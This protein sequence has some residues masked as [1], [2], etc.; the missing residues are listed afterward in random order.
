MNR[1]KSIVDCCFIYDEIETL[2]FRISELYDFVDYFIITEYD[3]DFEGKSKDF[4]YEK[5]NIFFLDWMDKIIY[6]KIES[7]NHDFKHDKKNQIKIFQ[8]EIFEKLSKMDLKFEDFI[9]FSEVDEI[10]PKFDYQELDKFLTYEPVAFLQKNFIGSVKYSTKE[11]H[12]GS[13]CFLLSHFVEDQTLIETLYFNKNSIN[14]FYYRI[15]EG[16]F[17][18]SHFADDESIIR[19]VRLNENKL[20]SQTEIS[21]F[22]KNLKYWDENL[23]SF[24]DYEGSLPKNISMIESNFFEEI[25]HRKF[26]VIL[27]FNQNYIEPHQFSDYDKIINLNFTSSFNFLPKTEISE[28][29]INYNIYIPNQ[30]YYESEKFELEF[31]FNEIKQI[32]KNYDPL[33]NDLFN[34]C[35]CDEKLRFEKTKTFSWREIKNNYMYQLLKNPS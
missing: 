35:I 25:T 5:K 3:L 9:I 17:H 20:I 32:L 22:K 28:N 15:L 34:F 31:G 18:F 12:L 11:K 23:N 1:K 2:K 19:K 33:N 21:L 26:M 14:S 30:K 6:L 27:N 16:G 24:E 10:P 7:K 13:F 8:K 29:F 4:N